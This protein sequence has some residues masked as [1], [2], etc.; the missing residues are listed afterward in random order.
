MALRNRG[1]GYMLIY[2]YLADDA[3]KS[4]R[5]S[6][7]FLTTDGSR[8]ETRQAF[9]RQT[10]VSAKLAKPLDNT[11]KSSRNSPTLSMTDGSYR[12]TRQTSRQRA[13]ISAKLAKLSDDGRKY[14][15]LS[16]MIFIRY[17]SV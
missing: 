15:Y 13:E 9:R 6:P 11:R 12:E 7:S 1:Y 10:E 5:N 3:R 4:S 8:R 2:V 14:P 16:F 17:H